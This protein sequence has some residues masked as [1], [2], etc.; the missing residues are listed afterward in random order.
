M[1]LNK[2]LLAGRL[3]ADPQLRTTQTGRQIAN[4]SI[5]TNRTWTDQ[6][7]QKQ[8][9][10]EYHNIVVWDRQAEIVSRFLVRGGLV[11]VEGRLQT[12]TWDDRQ[13]QRRRTTEIIAERVQFGPRAGGLS[14]PRPDAGGNVVGS[15]RAAPATDASSVE[16]VPT[17]QVDDPVAGEIKAEDLPF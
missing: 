13:G 16:E 9:A 8:E 6:G 15:G 4:F 10:V 2:V 3:T 17:V 7:G 14:G 1:N 12:R 5:A 11:L